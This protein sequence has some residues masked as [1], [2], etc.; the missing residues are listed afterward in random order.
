MWKGWKTS[1][2][3]KYFSNIIRKVKQVKEDHKRD[4]KM[5]F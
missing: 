4:G 2:S 3:Q 1:E 5:K